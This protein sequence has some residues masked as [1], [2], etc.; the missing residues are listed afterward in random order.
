MTPTT[1]GPTGDSNHTDD[2]ETIDASPP[3]EPLTLRDGLSP[4]IDTPDALQTYARAIGQGSGP[5]A[6]DAELQDLLPFA[7][8]GAQAR[9]IGDIRQDLERPVPMH[10]LLQGDVGAGKTAVA[11]A[12]LLQCLRHG[13]PAAFM[14]PTELLAV[15][16][17]TAELYARLLPLV[18]LIRVRVLV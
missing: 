12:A 7:L 14:A 18:H 11:L 4:V 5:V 10:R 13:L 17:V 8:T 15:E 16:P 3:L 6:L 9:A 2:S 1:D